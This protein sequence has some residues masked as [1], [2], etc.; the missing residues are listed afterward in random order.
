MNETKKPNILIIVTDQQHL[1]MMS[2]A[3][4]TYLKTPAID[5]LATHGVRCTRAYCSNPVCVP[6]RFSLFTGRMPSAIGMRSNSSA[7]TTPYTEQYQAEGMGH[8][9]KAAGYTCVY[10]GKTHFPQQMSAGDLGF[11]YIEKDERDDLARVCADWLQQ[12]HQQPFAMVASLINPHD[13]CYM[14]I[15][16]FATSEFDHK[17]LERG[18]TEVATLDKALETPEG[19]SEEEFFNKLC[20][21]LPSNHQPQTDEPE[22]IRGM[23][24]QRSF[25]RQ[26]RDEWGEKEWRMH[27]WAYARLTEVVDKQIQQITDALDA[28]GQRDNTIIIFTSDHGDHD[29]SHKLEHKTAFYNEADN[30]PFIICD[31]SN[32][33]PG[34]VNTSALIN[35]GLDLFPT[36]CDYANAKMPAHISG[37]SL[38]NL[39][40]GQANSLV[41]DCVYAENEMSYMVCSER[42]KYVLYDEGAH[43]EQLY[44][45][46]NDPDQ[47]RN[48]AFD[49]DKQS[50]LAEHR[51]MLKQQRTFYQNQRIPV[52]S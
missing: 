28:S 15:R 13:I 34:S 22:M 29:A 14:A 50:A 31:P 21:P 6:S 48:A 42:Y 39:A 16:A 33:N 11:E 43:N 18:A 44:D 32:P 10:G 1:N 45:L 30:V 20:P 38:R 51:E 40:N 19:M 3:G 2:C 23:I 25:K 17:L 7:D 37:H 26:A 24:E 41:R 52:A 27:R 8:C 35:N 36:V 9:L 46:K 5:A 4:N 47:M 49:E 12:D